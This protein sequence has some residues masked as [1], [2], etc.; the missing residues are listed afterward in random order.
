[1]REEPS[2]LS[3][4]AISSAILYR[5]PIPAHSICSSP[6]TPGAVFLHLHTEHEISGK[7]NGVQGGV[8]VRGYGIFFL[9]FLEFKNLKES[10]Y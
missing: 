9:F 5:L 10:E 7:Q 4:A 1:M 8:G 3:S 2:M 6:P